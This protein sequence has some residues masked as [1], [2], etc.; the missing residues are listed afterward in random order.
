METCAED[1]LGCLRAHSH[2]LHV[3]NTQNAGAKSLAVQ[4]C[5]ATVH[6]AHRPAHLSHPTLT[7][8][9]PSSPPSAILSTRLILKSIDDSPNANSSPTTPSLSLN[10]RSSSC[11]ALQTRINKTSIPPCRIMQV[12]TCGVAR[13]VNLIDTIYRNQMDTPSQI[14]FLATVNNTTRTRP[15]T[16]L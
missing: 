1:R 6:T 11:L 15:H 4:V 7:N 3:S 8:H 10:R 14:E 12:S 5:V 13:P 16:D 9:P 2:S